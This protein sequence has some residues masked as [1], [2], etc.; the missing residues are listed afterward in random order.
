[1]GVDL[2]DYNAD[3]LP[4]LWVA[5]FEQE[6]FSLYRNDGAAQFREPLEPHAGLRPRA[7][8]DI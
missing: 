8:Q 7:A 2:G 1:M 6:S 4:D 3:G 5:E